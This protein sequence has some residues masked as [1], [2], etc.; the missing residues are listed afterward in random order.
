MNNTQR[1]VRYTTLSFPP[2]NSSYFLKESRSKWR[3]ETR[4]AAS[5]VFSGTEADLSFAK[6][7]FREVAPPVFLSKSYMLTRWAAS[8]E[9]TALQGRQK[10][11]RGSGLRARTFQRSGAEQDKVW[12]EG[13]GVWWGVLLRRDDVIDRCRQVV[14]PTFN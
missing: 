6:L 4:S 5:G 10:E 13:Q 8:H 7:P 11:P 9:S 14:A 12:Y 1:S 3:T 2:V